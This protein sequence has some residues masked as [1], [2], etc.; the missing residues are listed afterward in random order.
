[1]T[2]SKARLLNSTVLIALTALVASFSPTSVFAQATCITHVNS[3][4]GDTD[5]GPTVLGLTVVTNDPHHHTIGS[6][7]SGASASQ[8]GDFGCAPNATANGP[9]ATAIGDSANA[10]GENSTSVGAAAG[11]G[12]SGAGNTAF[13]FGAG[14]NVQG[15]GNTAV[16]D[17]TGTNVT[18]NNNSAFGNNSGNSVTGDNN[19]AS[20][21]NSGN[22]VLG[23]SNVAVGD[24]SGNNISA[25]DTI[26]VGTNANGGTT[27]SIAIGSNSTVSAGSASF[28][29]GGIAIGGD[30]NNDGQGAFARGP[31][32]IAIGSDAVADPEINNPGAGDGLATA[33]GGRAEARNGR[34][35]AIGADALATGGRTTAIGNQARASGSG[36]V[37][38]GDNAQ[39]GFPIQNGGVPNAVAVG[40]NT[41]ALAAGS[42]AIGADSTATSADPNSGGA[43][44]RL[45]NEFV[46]GTV[47]HTYTAPG[48]TSDLSRERQSGPLELVT[49]DADGHVASDGGQIFRDLGK[50][51]AGIAIATALE[52]PDLVGNETFGLAANMGSFDGNTAIAVSA[53]GVLGRDFLGSGE[54][55]AVSGGVGVSLNEKDYGGQNTDRAVAGRAGVQVTW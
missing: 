30:V 22:N 33:I 48:I 35:T 15:D 45:E 37:A 26:A 43:V 41:K 9:N 53:M 2:F 31:R 32:S 29:D 50:Q 13:G 40:R 12:S 3:Q 38:V 23:S 49:T 21:N 1:M 17:P 25:S 6:S 36:S 16:G 19:S 27:K 20:G 51:G 42:V 39:T 24:N 52:N 4:T 46:L 8:S 34:A 11:A 54:R 44:A 47:N 18:G 10:N 5:L 14:Q 55:W 28:N 7:N